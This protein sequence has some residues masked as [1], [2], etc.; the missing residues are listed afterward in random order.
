MNFFYIRQFQ[1]LLNKAKSDF[2]EVEMENAYASE[3][4]LL[5]WL[6][7]IFKSKLFDVSQGIILVKVGTVPN[8]PEHLI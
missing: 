8:Q 4:K 2:L 3:M 5:I 7:S 1:V 6:H